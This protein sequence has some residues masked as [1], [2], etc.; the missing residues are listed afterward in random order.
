MAQPLPDDRLFGQLLDVVSRALE[1]MSELAPHLLHFL[2]V[3]STC[4]LEELHSNLLGSPGAVP[5]LTIACTGEGKPT[6]DFNFS[7]KRV[8]GGQY[9]PRPA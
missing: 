9:P 3:S 8:R 7:L 2:G 1:I 4:Y 6:G 5:Y